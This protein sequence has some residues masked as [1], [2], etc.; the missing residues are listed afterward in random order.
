[1]S[2]SSIRRRLTVR[3]RLVA[4]RVA[5]RNPALGVVGGAVAAGIQR[6]SPTE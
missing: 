1:M 2:Y 5:T 6:G 4:V 3:S